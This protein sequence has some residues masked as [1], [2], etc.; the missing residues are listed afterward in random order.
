LGI[1]KEVAN[2]IARC[3]E[4]QKVKTKHRHPVGRL[5][6]F[7]ILEWKWEFVTIDVITKLP[8]IVKQ[9]DF[10]MVVVDKFTKETHFILVNTTHKETNIAEI[11]MKEVDKIHGVPN[12]LLSYRDPK[13]TSNFRNGLFNGFGTNLNLST[14]YYPKSDGQTE[15]TNRIIEDRLRMYVM[16]QPSKWEDYINL[17]EFANNNGYQATLKMSL[18]EA[19]HGRKCNTPVSWDNPAYRAVVGPNLLKET[20]EK[21]IKIKKNLKVAQDRQKIYADNNIVFR[22]F[23]VGEHVF[24]K[25][26]VKRSSIRLGSFPKLAARYCGPFEILEKIGPVA[27]MLAFPSSMRFHNVFH[28]SL[29]KKYVSDPNHIIDWNVTQVEHEG[30]F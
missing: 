12:A 5:Q 13:F 18:F 4:C 11:Y 15:R 16:D 17:V 22:D 29:L 27:Y 3:I 24:L 9:H 28:V 19:L 8:K 7:P 2:Y 1:K 20:E 26:K 23:K 21:M 10:I 14:M 30:D 25:V 6:L